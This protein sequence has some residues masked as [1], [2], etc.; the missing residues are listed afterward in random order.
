MAWVL[1]SVAASC[2]RTPDT[3]QDCAKEEASRLGGM[4][5]V[6]KLVGVGRGLL[7]SGLA[8]VLWYAVNLQCVTLAIRQKTCLTCGWM[9]RY[10]YEKL[11]R[12][13]A[14]RRS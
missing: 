11:R 13:Q 9:L 1:S 4:V 7:A 8:R 6:G 14:L 12:P 2:E 3:Q 10:G 5:A